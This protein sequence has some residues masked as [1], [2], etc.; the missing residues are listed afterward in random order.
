MSYRKPV[1]K[2]ITYEGRSL[3]QE[4]PEAIRKIIRREK[5]KQCLLRLIPEFN[6]L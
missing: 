4:L 5:P 1:Y 2:L 6:Q 3:H